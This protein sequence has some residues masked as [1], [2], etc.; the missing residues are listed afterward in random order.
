ML[1]PRVLLGAPGVQKPRLK[2]WSRILICHG[3]GEGGHF[4]IVEAA[5]VW[6]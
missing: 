2:R 3:G 4:L 6:R 1:H 5:Q